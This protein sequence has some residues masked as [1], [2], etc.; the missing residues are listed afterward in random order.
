MLGLS[1]SQL[2]TTMST[3]G[4]DYDNLS[5]EEREARDKADREREQSEQA[6]ELFLLLQICTAGLI[7]F[8]ASIVLALPYRWSQRL[9]DVDIEVPVPKGTRGRDLNVVIQKKKL[10]VS[11]KGQDPIMSGEL[12]KDI[13][14][15][16][17]TWTLGKC[18]P[19]NDHLLQSQAISAMQRTNR[20][21]LCT[22]RK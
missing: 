3:S 12:C 4:D 16:E 9:A 19:G 22:S 21:Y 20:R 2:Q 1:T 13:K 11:L 5:K 6:G 8:P 17:S 18:T 15:E 7:Q 10:S 14:V